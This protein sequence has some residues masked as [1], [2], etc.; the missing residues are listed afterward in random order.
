MKIKV[1]IFALFCIALAQSQTK[2]ADLVNLT[3]IGWPEDIN[4]TAYSG[5][6]DLNG[7]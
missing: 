4:F 7:D 5:Y 3:K 6:L 2:D 1:V